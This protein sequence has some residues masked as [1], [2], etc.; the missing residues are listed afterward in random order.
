MSDRPTQLDAGLEPEAPDHRDDEAAIEDLRERLPE[1]RQLLG[2][3]DGSDDDV[4][5]MSR[6]RAYTACLNPYGADIVRSVDPGLRDVAPYASDITSGKGPGAY[7]VHNYPTKVPHEAIMRFIL[8][9]T[10]PGDLVLDGFCG[11]GMTGLAAQACKAPNDHLR[12]EIEA[13]AT[14]AIRWGARRAFLQDLAPTATFIAAGL[15]LPVD[16]ATFDRVSSTLMDRFERE[17]GWMYET[18]TPDGRK[19]KIDFTVWSEVMTCQHC[20]GEIVFYDAAFDDASGRVRESFD[21]PSCGAT[22]GKRSLKRRKVPTTTLMGDSTERIEY[23]PVMIAYR[24]GRESGTKRPEEAD[25]AVLR[26]IASLRLSGV[27]T[28]NLPIEE[29][30]H[31]SRLE[32][33]GFTK[34][35]HL[36]GD[37]A[38]TSISVLWQWAA[39]HGDATVRNA[40]LF[41]VEQALWTMSRMNRYQRGG[42]SQVNKQLPGVYYV[43]SIQAETSPQYALV[44]TTPSR[45]KRQALINFWR[46]SPASVDNIRISTASS[47]RIALPDGSVDYVFVDP[48]FGANIPYSDLAL[49]IESWHR[50]KTRMDAEATMDSF[51][52]RGLPE[53]SILMTSCFREFYR[54]LRP[55]RW[56][57]VEFSNS[58]NAV[59][60]AIQQA[61]AGSGFVVADTRGFDKELHSY[62]QVTAKNA[63]KRDLIIS[64]YKPSSEVAERVQLAAGS[65]EGVWE[66]VREHLHHLGITEEADGRAKDVRERQLDRLFESMVGYHV[67]SGIAVPMSLAEFAA[68]MDRR[69]N[70]ADDMYFLPHQEE[71][72]QRF[73]LRVPRAEQETAFVTSEATA[74]SWIRRRLDARRQTY[75]EIQPAFFT[76][77]QSGI[78]GWEELPELRSL[79][80]DNFL[81]DDRD[82]WF[83]PDPAQAEHIDRIRKQAL[84][85]V[86]G[87]Y[88]TETGPLQ[89]VRSDAVRVGFAKAWNDRD[90]D[91]IH[92]VGR[93]LSE[94]FFVDEPVLHHYYRAAERRA[95]GPDP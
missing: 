58:S 48:P 86:F 85:R 24:V 49:V 28:E 32:P 16:A 67:A 57:T 94:D 35:H 66:F 25:L 53:Y 52:H 62:R 83:A 42:F 33:K 70:L 91:T 31:G 92:R 27:P 30:V 81:Q 44:G 78:S 3:P 11:S 9:Y 34:I 21:C 10:E 82:R 4:L 13:E 87:A 68:G 18:R 64:V 7:W 46:S 63:V 55:G 56:M 14:T 51:K 90:F 12:Q 93:R 77:V 20:A 8:H 80:Q 47:E 2:S 50:V 88:A 1:L 26:R 60:L 39:E 65:E 72:Y 29:M 95:D 36:W 75:A 61:L 43:P 38:L 45:G 73:R 40:L 84:L 69:F 6:P 71:E 59:W 79:L 19:A 76:E 15:N 37:R 5:R 17:W 41:W 23:R 22:V 89:N 54:V 74:I